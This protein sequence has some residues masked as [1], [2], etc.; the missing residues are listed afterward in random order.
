MLRH[1]GSADG[2][3][4]RIGPHQYRIEEDLFFW[5]PHGEVGPDHARGVVAVVLEIHKRHGRVLYLLD[6]RDGKPLGPDT[7]RIVV[8][9]LRPLRGS[10]AIASFG[11]GWLN[12]VAGL[13]LFR[14]AAVLTGFDLP[15]KFA[16]TEAEARAF[17]SEHRKG[18]GQDRAPEVQSER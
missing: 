2:L 9:S 5:Q 7:R 11:M 13:L 10:L 17:L 18:L 8:D 1:K 3:S 4:L 14:A 16:S 12:R 6:G 15:F